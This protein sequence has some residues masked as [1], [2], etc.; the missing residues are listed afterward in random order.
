MDIYS[1]VTLKERG[2]TSYFVCNHCRKAYK[3]EGGT[4]IIK[5]HLK[6]THKWYLA[7]SGIA[8]KRKLDGIA[9]DQA[10]LQGS[11]INVA[12]ET[13]RRQEMLGLTLDKTTME[14]LYIQWIVECDLPFHQVAHK[15]FRRFFEYINPVTNKLLPNSSSTI[16]THAQELFAEGKKRLRYIFATA[17]SD[18]H[19]TCDM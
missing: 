16:I 5:D 1:E 11:N 9:I 3:R 10:I 15:S 12:R 18:I 17:I 19:I 8:Q 4:R 7:A 2:G 6:K 13:K 14:Y